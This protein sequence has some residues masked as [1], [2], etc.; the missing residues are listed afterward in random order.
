MKHPGRRLRDLPINRM[1]PNIL[2]ILALCA[3]LIAIRYGLQGKWE[4]AIVAVLIAGIFDGLDGRVARVLNQTSRFGAELDSLSDFI[5][6]GVAPAVV[7]YLWSLQD[8]GGVGWAVV[9]LFGV[10]CALRLARFNTRLEQPSRPAWAERFFSGV[11]APAGAGLALMPMLMAFGFDSD[12]FRS[13]AVTIPV[14]AGTAALMVSQM[15]TFSLKGEHVPQKYALPILLAVGLLA[16]L[17]ASI[18]WLTLSVI[19]LAYLVSIPFSITRYR[20]L[21]AAS[22]LAADEEDD[23]PFISIADEADERDLSRIGGGPEA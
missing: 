13:P 18:P 19:G 3:G 4:A 6:F 17:L 20:R 2:T 23:A 16:G 1:I 10:C 7:V 9:M 5:S 22:E 8:T 14:L 11:P 21:R 15:S 12:V